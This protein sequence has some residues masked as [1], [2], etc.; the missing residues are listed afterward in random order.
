MAS[1]VVN[2]PV[3]AVVAPIG[4]LS[5]LPPVETKAVVV[6]VP[7]FGT[8]LN[9]VELVVCGKFPVVELTTVG[10][11]VATDVVLSVIA[12]FVAF[13]A[14]VALVA[15]LALPVKAPTKLVDVTETK[16][17]NVVTVAPNATEVEP[18]V[19]LELV[20]AALGILVKPAPEPLKAVD[21]KVPVLGTYCNLVELVSIVEV[22]PLVAFTNVG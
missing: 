20:N 15:V 4:V 13:V 21:V 3:L 19:T 16:P 7:V 9:L 6:K 18:M 11:Q 2:L 1:K 8:K 5:I 10:Y 12:V 14:V 17:A 22:V